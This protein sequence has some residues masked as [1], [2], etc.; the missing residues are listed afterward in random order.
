MI[1]AIPIVDELQGASKNAE[2]SETSDPNVRS[3]SFA[4]NLVSDVKNRYR[5]MLGSE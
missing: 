2:V 5:R 3:I 1:N 4:Q